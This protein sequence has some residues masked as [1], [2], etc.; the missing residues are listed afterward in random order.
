MLE[1]SHI[2]SKQTHRPPEIK[3]NRCTAII[4]GVRFG[5]PLGIPTENVDHCNGEV[6]KIIR[7]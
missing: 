1:P 5:K 7:T 2:K 4:T 3:N 6:L